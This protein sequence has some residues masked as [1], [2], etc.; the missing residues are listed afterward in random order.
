MAAEEKV[1]NAIVVI[2]ASAGGFEPLHEILSFLP[3]GYEASVFIVMHIGPHPSIL[4]RIIGNRLGHPAV[5]AE[6]E[7]QSS[8]DVS[9]SRRPI[10]TCC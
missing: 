8:Q 2:A 1:D 7:W 6:A 4:P 3:I 5:F 10:A 9:T